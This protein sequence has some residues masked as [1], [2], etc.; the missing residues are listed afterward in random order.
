A[1]SRSEVLGGSVDSV[2]LHHAGK[3]DISFSMVDVAVEG[4]MGT[5]K[6]K[7]KVPMRTLAVVHPL[8]MHVVTAEG[9]GIEKMSD[10]KGKRVSTGSPGSGT[11]GMAI[12][13]L[14]ADGDS[15]KDLVQERLSGAA[16]AHAH[17]GHH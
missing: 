4:M 10:R 1:Q 9:R 11:E 5:G 13:I 17:K 15:A 8:V 2:Q 12:R 16:A 6:F 14:E 3:T 7:D